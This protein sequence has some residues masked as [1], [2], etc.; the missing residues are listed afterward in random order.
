MKFRII[1]W[2]RNRNIWIRRRGRVP[3][4]IDWKTMPIRIKTWRRASTIIWRRAW[5]S[6]ITRVSTMPRLIS[7]RRII[8]SGLLRHFSSDKRNWIL[9]IC[10]S[11]K[12]SDSICRYNIGCMFWIMLIITKCGRICSC[13]ELKPAMEPHTTFRL[14]LHDFI[15]RTFMQVMQ[16]TYLIGVISTSN[17]IHHLPK[18][19]E[20]PVWI[21]LLQKT[22]GQESIST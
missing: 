1:R 6:L 7:R 13:E 2:L 17:S 11:R 20:K 10:N 14:A 15:T 16:K 5:M 12:R 19:S 9:N 21:S 3:L 8:P 22:P 18:R 4:L